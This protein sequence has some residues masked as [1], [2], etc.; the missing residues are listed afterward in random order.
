MVPTKTHTS[1]FTSPRVSRVPG[2]ERAYHWITRVDAGDALAVQLQGLEPNHIRPMATERMCDVAV[3]R[4][5]AV[6]GSRHVVRVAAPRNAT[7]KSQLG[8]G[9]VG[10]GGVL[11]DAAHVLNALLVAHP[12]LV[13]CVRHPAPPHLGC[14]TL[15][16]SYGPPGLDT[17]PLASYPYVVE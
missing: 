16:S 8:W 1:A 9:D 11:W 15:F 7:G 12:A 3:L 13:V 6:P 17:A 14:R 5:V 4:E 10:S 2:L